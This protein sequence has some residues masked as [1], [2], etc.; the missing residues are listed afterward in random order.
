MSLV[1]YPLAKARGWCLAAAAARHPEAALGLHRPTRLG[2][3]R[4]HR[5]IHRASRHLARPGPPRRSSR[6][7][8]RRVVRPGTVS[9]LAASPAERRARSGRQV[10][11]GRTVS[12]PPAG[13]PQPTGSVSHRKAGGASPPPFRAGPPRRNE[14]NIY[15][16]D[17]F[18]PPH[19]QHIAVRTGT[20]YGKTS[21]ERNGDD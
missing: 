6:L 13:G 2:T 7:R 10:P 8:A 18:P 19:M 1:R 15:R 16:P 9:P 11:G 12:L 5:A 17:V 20:R 21:L 3:Q 4:G 14:V